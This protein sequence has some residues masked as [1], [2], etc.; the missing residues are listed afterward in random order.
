MENRERLARIRVEYETSGIDIADVDPDPFLQFDRWLRNAIDAG[1]DEPNSFVLATVGADGRPSTRALLLK[2]YDAEGF[3]FFTN[4]E[5]RK[6]EEIDANP[7]VAMCFVWL[8]IHRQVRIEGVA[9]R[10]PEEVSDEYFR[11]RPLGARI[12]AH[13]SVQSRVIPDRT[14]LEQRAEDAANEFGTDPPRPVH[15]GGYLVQ[16]T[17]F[18]FWQGRPSRL[19]DRILY[20]PDSEGWSRSRLAP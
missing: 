20:R 10:L 15:W 19:H 11:S 9:R 5:S 2:G 6:A 3:S 7:H 8:P 4:Y 16:P 13:A 18:E 12:G 1:L 14:W 17:Q